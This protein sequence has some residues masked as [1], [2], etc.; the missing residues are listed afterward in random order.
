[1][2]LEYAVQAWNPHLQRDIDK[3]ERVQR[4][5]TRIPTGFDKLEYEDRL[6]RLSLTT[7]Q[8]RRMRGDLIET[9]KVLSN[10][11]SIDWVKPLNLRKNV[12][13]SGP[14]LNV[15]GNSF[16]MRRESFSSKVRNSFCSW[17][18]IRDN[19]FVNRVVQTWNSFPNSIVT[20]PS[21]NSFKSSID[22]HFKRFG[23]YSF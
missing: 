6:K 11:E 18:T 10:R 1:M 14:A 9:Y 4:R 5:A 17:A 7:L 22:E 2:H 13:I 16:S 15:R 12:D 23:C 20:Y 21:L 8:D 19:F 3:I